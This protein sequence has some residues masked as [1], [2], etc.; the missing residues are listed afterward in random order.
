MWQMGGL[1]PMAGQAHHFRN[2]AAE[3]QIPYAIE[4]YTNECNRLYGVMN[5]RLKDRPFLAGKYS[6]ADMAC[7]GWISRYKQQGQDLDEF[8]HLKR[9]FETLMGRPA[10]KRGMG[11]RV[12]AA[13]Q[14]DMKDPKV[15]AVLF[16]QRARTA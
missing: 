11:V 13:A 6:I 2:Y 3:I 5:L 1:G 7:I 10:V 8:P 12:E 9:W 15:R 16:T 14:V 4:R